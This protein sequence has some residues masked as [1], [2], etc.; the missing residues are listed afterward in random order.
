MNRDEIQSGST[1]Q[2]TSDDVPSAPFETRQTL[3]PA[4]DSFKSIAVE[5]G[6]HRVDQQSGSSHPNSTDSPSGENN[7]LQPVISPVETTSISTTSDREQ[8]IAWASRQV[9]NFEAQIQQLKHNATGR[10]MIVT[11]I[12]QEIELFQ[13]DYEALKSK[14]QSLNESKQAQL[15]ELRRNALEVSHKETGL[16]HFQAI[17][18]YYSHEEERD[19]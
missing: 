2:P 6:G 7:A 11:S 17:I 1:H 5:V 12:D 3:P 13:K 9:E 18:N 19:K 10:T 15:E 4:S 16:T 14:L 8:Q